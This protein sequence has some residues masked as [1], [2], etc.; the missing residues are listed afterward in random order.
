MGLIIN[1]DLVV[2]RGVNGSNPLPDTNFGYITFN[3]NPFNLFKF[4]LMITSAV[5][6]LFRATEVDFCR[7][8]VRYG[9]LE[10][11]GLVLYIFAKT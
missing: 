7:I 5:H 10:I 9:S 1:Y 6:F 4:F 11:L 2:L 3:L 8:R